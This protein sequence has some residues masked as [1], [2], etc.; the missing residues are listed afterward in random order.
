MG[1]AARQLTRLFSLYL[2]EEDVL[3]HSFLHDLSIAYGLLVRQAV[4]SPQLCDE[5]SQE[6]QEITIQRLLN[7]RYSILL[8]K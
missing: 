6:V 8:F 5:L 2:P 1:L 7:M 4:I 3:D